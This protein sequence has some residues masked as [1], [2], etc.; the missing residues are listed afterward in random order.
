VQFF[1]GFIIYFPNYLLMMNH[2]RIFKERTSITS[3]FHDTESLTWKIPF[4]WCLRWWHC[5][6][7][8]YKFC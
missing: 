6:N 2:S 5:E 7:P 3:I 1:S 8:W 4:T